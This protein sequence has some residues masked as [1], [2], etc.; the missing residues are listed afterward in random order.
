M[1]PRLHAVLV[2]LDGTLLDT[3]PDF[4]LV[5]NRLL[6]E[7]ARAPLPAAAIRETVSDGSHGMLRRAFGIGADEPAFGPLRAR[8]LELYA[9]NLLVETVPFPGIAALLAMLGARG[10]G[11]GVVTNKPHHLAAPLLERARLAPAPGVLVCPEHVRLTKP[12]PE[13]LLLACARLG[14]GPREALYVG[15]HPRDIEAGRRA[16]MPTV[17]AGWG[18]LADGERAEE[19]QADFIARSVPELQAILER[20]FLQE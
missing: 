3:A 6:A 15:D 8:L 11:W 1:R 5:I 16:G 2:D 4:V 13:A 19:W 7:H 20:H 10:L 17:A 18:Y 12:D 9:A 14:C